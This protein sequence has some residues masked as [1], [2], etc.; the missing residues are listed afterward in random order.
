MQRTYRVY[1]EV[2][3]LI[4]NA[5]MLLFVADWAA[6]ES[7]AIATAGRSEYSHAAKA[8]W[9]GDD[10]FVLEMH[11]KYGGR[12]VL[13]S[14][15]LETDGGRID[16]YRTNAHNDV[17]YSSKR[18]LKAMRQ[19]MG[20]RYAWLDIKKMALVHLPFVRWFFTPPTEDREQ[21]GKPWVCSGACAH[22]DHA[23]GHKPVPNLAD[24]WVEPGDLARSDFY[25]YQFTLCASA[26][27]RDCYE[28]LQKQ[29]A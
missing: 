28:N 2:R 3:K 29:Q 19:L 1:S 21:N 12:A 26:Q 7:H 9:W 18:A 8:A 15:Y 4:R 6:L 16:V 17:H 10:L 11:S 13:A 23:G 20:R 22:A 5:D 25:R 14:N 27:Q 24:H